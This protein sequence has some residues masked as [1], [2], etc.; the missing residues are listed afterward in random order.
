[1][2][3]LLVLLAATLLAGC[4][5]L[6]FWEDDEADELAP[7]ELVDFT[8]E[9]DIRKLWSRS[10][11]DGPDSGFSSL[12]PAYD[13]GVVFAADDDGDVAAV[14]TSSG[15]VLW[16][17]DLDRDLSGGVGVGC[18]LVF[19]GDLGGRVI[20][21]D[22]ASGAQRWR[23]QVGGEILSAPSCN[24]EIA[25]VQTLDGYLVALHAADGLEAWRYQVD[26]PAL[27]LRS[28]SSPV[29]T[30][31]TVIGGF[32]NGKVVALSTSVGSLLW[33]SRL[34]LPK[35]RTELERM[36]DIAGS[37]VLVDDVVYVASYQGRTTAITRGTGRSLWQQELSSYR[38]PGVGMDLVYITQSDDEVKA[39]RANSGQESWSNVQMRYRQLTAP[40]YARGYVA[41]GD[42]EGHLHV[43]SAKTGHYVARRKVDGSGLSQPMVTD[44][45][46]IYVLDNDGGLSAFTFSPR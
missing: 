1:M 12:R 21:L 22:R 43:L 7:A 9:I 25:V 37:P 11:G 38:Q 17:V 26:I 34:A 10:I 40:I 31:N 4:S 2:R 32:A 15:K 36:V 28:G 24:G 42:S 35:G 8:P 33:E 5:S 44:G 30:E 23:V 16:K 18:N 46:A 6:R 13:G 14:S 3:L 29:V 19:V 27:I 45:E 39:L 20:A 41:V